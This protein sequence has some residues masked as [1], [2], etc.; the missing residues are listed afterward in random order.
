M[1][2]L[3]KQVAASALVVGCFVSLW[4]CDEEIGRGIAVENEADT[5]SD[6][7]LP[8]D[9]GA[10]DASEDAAP[11]EDILEGEDALED[12]LE[13]ADALED[14]P[15][16]D[17]A[18]DGG[19]DEG[20]ADTPPRAISESLR[21]LEDAALEF[22]LR[23]ED[24]D[25][26][27]L[28]FRIEQ[29]PVRGVLEGT[30]PALIY[31]PEANF[32]GQDSVVF[33]VQD[34][35]GQEARGEI[36]LTV[37]AVEDAPVAL[38]QALEMNED[39]AL[40]LVLT[41]VD[42]DT[43]SSE[44]RFVVEEEP[45]LGRLE[46]QGEALI[47][48]PDPDIH[49]SDAFQFSV[50]DGVERTSASISIEVRSVNDAPVAEDGSGQTLEDEALEFVLVGRDVET[51]P[52][53]L[54][55]RIVEP[56]SSGRLEGEPPGVRYVPA[57]DFHGSDRWTFQVGDGELWS[58]EAQVLVDVEAINDPPRVQAGQDASVPLSRR[59]FLTG[60]ASDD[61][62]PGDE[63]LAVAWSLE[64]GPGRATFE[65]PRQAQGEVIFDAPGLYVLR[66]MASDGALIAEDF[67]QVEV[68]DDAQNL[69]P[70]V[71]AGPDRTLAL[72][73]ALRLEGKASDDGK[74]TPALATRWIVV[75]G[76]ATLDDPEDL[77]GTVRFPS[78]GEYVLRLEAS[79]GELTGQD[80]VRI[81]VEEDN[82]APIVDAG[83]DQDT[84]ARAVAL[85][86]R[87]TDDGLPG[88][89]ALSFVWSQRSGPPGAQIV[90][91]AEARTWVQLPQGGEY[92]FALSAS[93]GA[94]EAE[95]T[96]RVVARGNQPPEVFAG[97][98][99]TALLAPRLDVPPPVTHSD[100]PEPAWRT[101]IESAVFGWILD[102]GLAV[103]EDKLWVGFAGTEV[104]GV[105]TPAG[106]VSWDD[107]RW[108]A[109]PEGL[110]Y[111]QGVRHSVPIAAGRGELVAGGVFDAMDGSGNSTF[112][113]RYDG[114]RWSNFMP[115]LQIRAIEFRTAAILPH[116]TYVGG[117]FDFFD[118]SGIPS[119]GPAR[120]H[121]GQWHALEGG[122]NGNVMQIIDDGG[123]GIYVAG[124][125]AEV[126]G[127]YDGNWNDGD[128]PQDNDLI[129]GVYASNV[130]H[131][132]GQRWS[133][134]GGAF[135]GCNRFACTPTALGLARAPNGNL[136]V[137]GSFHQIGGVEVNSLA[138]LD[139]DG[140]RSVGGGVQGDVYA[141]AL[142]RGDLWA[143][144]DFFRAGGQNISRLARWDGQAFSAPA[145][146][147]IDSTVRALA[148]YRDTIYVG[149]T[150]N[151]FDGRS[152]PG[153]AAYG[154]APFPELTCPEPVIIDEASPD[155]VEVSLT[156]SLGHRCAPAATLTWAVD[157]EAPEPVDF[158][159]GQLAPARD[160][161]LERHFAPGVHRVT[162]VADDGRSTQSCT[163]SV[164]V[165][166]GV[167]VA[168]GG[169]VTDD[170]LPDG[171]LDARWSVVEG[172]EGASLADADAAE[173]T[174][175]VTEPGSYRLR[176]TG[177]DGALTGQDDVV[178]Q[179]TSEDVP[180]RG[181]RV[182]AGRDRTVT[183]FEA[184]TLS[185]SALDDGLPGPLAVRW[186]QLSG[187]GEAILATPEA[188]TTEVDLPLPGTWRF[189]LSADDGEL[190]GE[191]EVEVVV[192]DVRNEAPVVTLQGDNV[193][194]AGSP[195]RLRVAVS[196]DGWPFGALRW[197]LEHESG[198]G[199]VLFR[200]RDGRDEAIFAQ[201]GEHRVRVVAQDGLARSEASLAVRVLDPQEVEP[202]SVAW[203]APQEGERVTAGTAI[204]GQVQG[205]PDVRWRIELREASDEAAPWQI[206][207]Q[208]AGE[209]DGVLGRLDPTLKRNGAWLL[210]IVAQD[211][212]GQEVLTE[213]VGISIEGGMK[214]GASTLAFVDTTI[215][216]PG[217]E[218]SVVRSYDSRDVRVGDFGRGWTLDLKTVRIQKNTPLATS[219]R[220]GRLG[221]GF[222]SW[223][224]APRRRHLVSAIFP[225][226]RVLRFEARMEPECQAGLPITAGRL[227][228]EALD[229]QS[230]RL[231]PIDDGTVSWGGSAPGDGDLV[232]LGNAG[233]YEPTR[234]RL[235]LED[236]TRYVI[237]E[238][239]GLV[240]LTDALGNA[241]EINRDGVVH[242]AGPGVRF[243]RD[244][245][246]RISR[247]VDPNGGSVS[248]EYDPQGALV[249][250]VDQTGALTRF[251]YDDAFRLL[252][253]SPEDGGGQSSSYDGDGRLVAQADE[254]GQTQSWERDLEVRQEIVRDALGHPTTMHYDAFGN[255]VRQVDALGHETRWVYNADGKVTEVIPPLGASQSMAYDEEG[256]LVARIDG[257]GRATRYTLDA[258]G[259]PLREQ[260]PGQG[261]TTWSYDPQG[262]LVGVTGPDGR[263]TALERD[264]QGRVTRA[265]DA[266]Q[267]QIEY[268]YEGFSV[269]T[270]TIRRDS[271]GDVIEEISRELDE[272]GRP[273]S[274]ARVVAT[275][276]GPEV[277]QTRWTRDAKGR[278]LEATYSDGARESWEYDAA[279]RTLVHVD[280]LDRRV[281]F[282]YDQAGRKIARLDPD[283]LQERW[284]Y[285]A[286]GRVI[287]FI[288]R[289]GQTTRT[290]YDP[291]GRPIEIQHPDGTTTRATFDAL[292]RRISETDAAGAVTTRLY[293]TE[294][295][296]GDRLLALTDPM[297]RTTRW[298]YDEA[299]N[300]A[301][302][303]DPLGR[304]TRFSHDGAGRLT[305][306]THPDGATL[307]TSYNAAGLVAAETDAEEQQTLY[308]W[309]GLHQLRSV[310]DPAGQVTR[311][312]WDGA[313]RLTSARDALD[314]LTT[315]T[316]DE[317]GR[318]VE[319]VSPLGLTERFEYDRAG[320]LIAHTDARG[321]TTTYAW[322]LMDRLL[323][324]SP[325]PRLAESPTE[326]EYDALHRRTRMT[327]ALG[328]TRYAY[329][330]LGRLLSEET[331]RGALTYDYDEAGHMTGLRSSHPGGADVAFAYDLSGLLVAVDDDRC[332]QTLYDHDASGALQGYRWQ[333]GS[334]AIERDARDRVTR[335]TARDPQDDILKQW[336][337]TYS[338]SGRRLSEQDARG[339][340]RTTYDA[341]GRLTSETGPLHAH[342]YR[343][344]A[345]GNRTGLDDQQNLAF[346]LND[347]PLDA[348]YDNQGQLLDD[349]V[350]QLRWDAQGR[351]AQRLDVPVTLLRDG[352][353]RLV[354]RR[355]GDTQTSY[356]VASNTPTGYSQIVE[357]LR[358]DQLQVVYC[359]GHAALGLARPGEPSPS[360]FI[361]DAS[362]SV[363]AVLDQ[364]GAITDTLD[365]DAFG[366]LIQRTGQTELAHQFRGQRF[367][368]A[369]GLYDLR[370]RVYDPARGRFLSPD[371]H[372][373]FPQR[374]VTRH[375]YLYAEN[376]PVNRLDPSGLFSLTEVGLTLSIGADIQTVWHKKQISA[377][378]DIAR[379][380]YCD[381][382]PA[383]LLRK[384]ALQGVFAGE[385]DW[386][387][388]LADLGTELMAQRLQ[389][390]NQV[391][392]GIY[393]GILDDLT[394]VG[395]KV[396]LFGVG[397]S[398][399][400]AALSRGASASMGRVT[401]GDITTLIEGWR[402][403]LAQ[404][405]NPTSDCQAVQS[406]KYIA[407]FVLDKSLN[408]GSLRVPI[409]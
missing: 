82:L 327:D 65:T 196:D 175:T 73:R 179:V 408:T 136:Y 356:L 15:E 282:R 7:D 235:T 334:I 25:G 151:T 285:D 288:D 40:A 162:L 112:V 237:D 74:P 61:G 71:D 390:I 76:G 381:V 243:E 279:G 193:G 265:T 324:R 271:Q 96:M 302:Q 75:S 129:D 114:A 9:A 48:E 348:L 383:A 140:W 35:R 117:F 122:V 335:W 345:V 236:G 183:P 351:L 341:L 254:L 100:P 291:L 227:V 172:P 304:V 209:R 109:P 309:D 142:Y 94:R 337:Y 269:P 245:Q 321:F 111:S 91:A 191:D 168:L 232:D 355:E 242:S 164:I 99:Q 85:D 244:D 84:E 267:N 165:N 126:G 206:V 404:A 190:L 110:R 47:Y 3:I 391:I 154:V 306:T 290:T 259:R 155:G 208:G 374:P 292:G 118:R 319:R 323:R 317:R 70:I 132:D 385:G 139:G 152:A 266:D 119:Y 368:P 10:E 198:P 68:L 64:R 89:G 331:P 249:G 138:Q 339:L 102:S 5:G 377:A 72:S 97:E 256:R 253:V 398:F 260:R 180:N 27:I 120:Y 231:E 8:L 238:R 277:R 316:Y 131:W 33:V 340:T 113:A 326:F 371:P 294:C 384:V 98:D 350:R 225:D 50:T 255:V 38:A 174:L 21:L 325:D 169:R 105:Q 39:E 281:E 310:T 320:R 101:E 13:G 187:P 246:G 23:G 278:P 153:L 80:E 43:P 203:T 375:P 60:E 185:G 330:A 207:A 389:S 223:C 370:A 14:A 160:V 56:P 141:I 280:P 128:G 218:V 53:A 166:A 213:P 103:S 78:P 353:G 233:L 184:V 116:G 352:D 286:V 344:D 251:E 81:L 201:A 313:G 248:Y 93:D 194:V 167:R 106:V 157:D 268:R 400:P 296:C 261:P 146:G 18:E 2:R 26:D 301:T 272:L 195:L 401:Q 347:R 45:T 397:F 6:A 127:T 247:L 49:G 406:F 92:V 409:N 134:L 372:G 349:G 171:T 250:V 343:Y 315:Y 197:T 333:G 360:R 289:A 284:E 273:L 22:L 396:Q 270:Q 210:R 379:V 87:A 229:G 29:G 1:S 221:Q 67:V 28:T 123:S 295:G 276:D 357:E 188:V 12:A 287:A 170:G 55:W 328:Q 382:Q 66:L 228:F 95:D 402:L 388:E 178:I 257:Q 204:E 314:R 230:A 258:Q 318:L 308:A 161:V 143:G 115:P 322:D 19:A 145:P 222:P 199:E 20:I 224:V 177:D 24:D 226:D 144:G 346:D 77:Q 52:E 176:L 189:A 90:N 392:N 373:G 283:G 156:G 393:T 362:E 104:A 149:G 57:Q 263:V 342:T 359:L 173:T 159:P 367:E 107:C 380:L 215:P 338:P 234:F 205:G 394:K 150:F 264:P 293:D 378:F 58:P 51:A 192:R 211:A 387:Y 399:N 147:L 181:P 298:S 239:Q 252:R 108:A 121:Q 212:I 297:G 303:T 336:L 386:A 405:S 148:T 135:T 36:A 329:D 17:V 41:A 79:D 407:D 364:D 262:N 202:M 124:T 133:A 32:F 63:A 163:T 31:R 332:G 4:G 358:D 403:V 88:D 34:G 395:V 16:G 217:V 361:L 311:Y 240:S 186:R 86:G 300:I 220:Q 200:R 46:G 299:G 62:Q 11:G 158:A 54:L 37:E 59:L 219:W 214:V 307:E 369:L 312:D 83:P 137:G 69:A 130:A 125:F 365:Y 376:D 363:R 30:P 42:V 305:S 366:N 274:E 354:G 275:P 216:T 241:V 44:L 182:D